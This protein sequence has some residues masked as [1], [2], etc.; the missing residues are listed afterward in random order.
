MPHLK[1]NDLA[2][3]TETIMIMIKEI[4]EERGIDEE[5]VYELLELFLDY[6][7][8]E[9]LAAL[10]EALHDG[11]CSL[12]RERAHSIKGAALN[13][14]LTEIVSVAREIE[15]KC[16]AADLAGV[17]DLLTAIAHQLRLVDDFLKQQC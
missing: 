4:A 17:E 8:T 14:K 7:Q 16:D 5:D 12:A 9:D 15:D 2:I 6:T 1:Q 13:L 3:L 11:N 10:R